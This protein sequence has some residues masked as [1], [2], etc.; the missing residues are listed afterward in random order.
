MEID[1]TTSAI[2]YLEMNNTQV[3]AKLSGTD[4]ELHDVLA[5]TVAYAQAARARLGMGDTITIEVVIPYD[6]PMR[7]LW[8]TA[9]PLLAAEYIGLDWHQWNVWT[10]ERAILDDFDPIPFVQPFKGEYRVRM[11]A[12]ALALSRH[13]VAEPEVARRV[14]A[15]LLAAAD[16]AELRQTQAFEGTQR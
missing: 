1:S 6:P 13:S 4:R 8:E 5:A 15:G 14:A 9:A 7:E 10:L 2:A 3:R 11:S 12:V 16:L